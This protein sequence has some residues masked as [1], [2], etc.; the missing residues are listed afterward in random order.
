[1]KK[2]ILK[3]C[4]PAGKVRILLIAGLVFII[5]MPFFYSGRN[6]ELVVSKFEIEKGEN[7][8]EVAGNLKDK[9]LIDGRIGFVFYIYRR[10]LQKE[11]KAGVALESLEKWIKNGKI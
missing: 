4:L 5:L 10:N 9:E 2:Y 1:M 6:G 7:I 11:I 8:W 3:T